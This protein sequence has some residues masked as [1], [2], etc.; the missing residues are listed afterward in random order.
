MIELGDSLGILTDHDLRS[1]VVAE[2]LS[3][4]APVSPAMSAP[5]F[6]VEPDRLGG[7][8]LLEML[9]RG[10]RHFPVSRRAA[11]S[12]ASSRPIDLLAV[13]TLSSFYLRR[14]IARAEDIAELARAAGVCAR[15]S[16]ALHEARLAAS[17]IAAIYSVVL[18]A[19]TRRLIELALT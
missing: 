7:D 15:P 16:I 6:T 10:V 13:E 1:R 5:A 8:V 14:A 18:D 17:S 9:D 3:Y 11:R 2:G 19:L 4:D 12:S